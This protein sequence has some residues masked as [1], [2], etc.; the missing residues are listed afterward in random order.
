MYKS[1]TLQAIGLGK[2]FWFQLEMSTNTQ[3]LSHLIFIYDGCRRFLVVKLDQLGL[4]LARWHIGYNSADFVW[5]PNF[6]VNKDEVHPTK[7][8]KISLLSCS[9]VVFGL[10]QEMW[11]FFQS[12]LIAKMSVPVSGRQCAPSSRAFLRCLRLFSKS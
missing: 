2:S 12:F 8:S 5:K 1:V 6:S 3:K 4:Y 10:N 7:A 11:L 9:G